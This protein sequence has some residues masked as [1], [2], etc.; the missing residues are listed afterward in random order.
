MKY[1]VRIEQQH[2]EEFEELFVCIILT[3]FLTVGIELSEVQ[4]LLLV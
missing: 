2:R 3:L 1:M 4:A